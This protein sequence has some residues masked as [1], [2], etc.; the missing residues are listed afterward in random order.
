MWLQVG[1]YFGSE[2]CALDVDR[3]G[4]TDYLLVGAPFFHIRGEE[5]KVYV[6]KLNNDD[7]VRLHAAAASSSK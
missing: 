7:M 4:I 5:G 3:N 6:Y 1:S 2:L